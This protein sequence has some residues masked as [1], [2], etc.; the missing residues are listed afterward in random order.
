M[1]EGLDHALTPVT[2]NNKTPH[3]DHFYAAA[4]PHSPLSRTHTPPQLLAKINKLL[5]AGADPHIG[6]GPAN[7]P[8]LATALASSDELTRSNLVATDPVVGPSLVRALVAAGADVNDM[9]S[10]LGFTAFQIA[11][12]DG[13]CAEVLQALLDVGADPCAPC[14]GAVFMS[15]VELA[16]L[17]GGD[18][19]AVRLLIELPNSG[20]LNAVGGLPNR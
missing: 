1:Y 13:A 17:R 6:T 4:C 12:L 10:T 5:A 16:A 20:G 3:R 7:L 8:A 19:R 9:T 15:P 11:C 18:P 14:A 2:L